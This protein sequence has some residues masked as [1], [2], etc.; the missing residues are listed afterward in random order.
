[1]RGLTCRARARC[2]RLN[3][4]EYVHGSSRQQEHIC[5]QHTTLREKVA[6]LDD[7]SGDTKCSGAVGRLASTRAVAWERSGWNIVIASLCSLLAVVGALQLSA[8]QAFAATGHR[9]LSS[10]SEAPAGRAL[11]EPDGV[12]VDQTSGDVFVADPGAGASTCSA[13]KERFLQSSGRASN[14]SSWPSMNRAAM[15][16]SPTRLPTRCSFSSPNGSGGY[17]LL[18]EWFGESTPAKEFGEVVGVAV[19]NSHGSASGDVYVLDR[20]DSVAETGVV[21]VFKPRPKGPEEAQEGEFRG[22]LS[23]AK[24]PE[25]NGVAVSDSSGEVFVADSVARRRVRVQ[26]GREPGKQAQGDGLA[27]GQLFGTRRRRRQRDRARGRRNDGRSARRRG[28]TAR[29]E[30]VQSRG[31]M[32]RLDHEQLKRE[33]FGEPRGVAV[34]STGDVYVADAG[35]HVVDVFGPGVV[36]PDVTTAAASKLTRTTR[37]V[38]R[39]GQ[40][41]RQSRALPLRMGYDRSVGLE[42]AGDERRWRRRKGRGTVGELQAGTSYFFRLTAENENG[43]NVGAIREFTTPPAVEGLTTGLGRKCHARQARR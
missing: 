6:R 18:S 11:Q 17:E 21:D 9:F 15:C 10:L 2:K 7:R 23:S 37:H 42:H 41:R 30:R 8:T 38:E 40:W 39:H 31:R 16:T 25:P 1:M 22:V 20:E 36:V 24:L 19:D 12:A 28:R 27:A 29:G 5:V 13:R 3:G 43:T 26:P 32:G 35:K 34:S 14:R 4:L 33:R